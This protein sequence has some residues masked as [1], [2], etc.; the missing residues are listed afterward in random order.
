MR[1]FSLITINRAARQAGTSMRSPV[2]RVNIGEGAA[3]A[4]VG[5]FGSSAAGTSEF[6]D[7]RK[8]E[9]ER[10]PENREPPLT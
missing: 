10:D 1:N 9:R 4:S 3:S 8:R 7:C 6:R 2:G 5:L